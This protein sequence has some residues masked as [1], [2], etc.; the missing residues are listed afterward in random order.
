[1]ESDFDRQK[2]PVSGQFPPLDVNALHSLRCI[3]TSEEIRRTVFS[4][5]KFKA[6]G[7]DGL[8][9][10]FFYT[11]WETIGNSAC[12]MV[13][14]IFIS[15][16]KIQ[17]IN[18]TLICLIPKE[19]VHS[20][21][22]KKGEIGLMAIKI[23][24]EKAYGRLNWDFVY[25]TLAYIGFPT[26]AADIIK[27]CISTSSM[28]LLWNGRTTMD[29]NPTRGIRQGDP[30]SPYLFVLCI[31][32]LS[33]LIQTAMGAKAWKPIR[34]KKNGPWLSH[35]FFAD[36]IFLF[37]DASLKQAV[38]VNQVLRVFCDASGQN[39]SQE[40]T[41]VFFSR[42]VIHVRSKEICDKLGYCMTNDLGGL[43]IRNLRVLNKA[44]IMKLGHGILTNRD[45]LWVQVLRSK[46]NMDDILLPSI[47]Q[48]TVASNLWRGVTKYWSKIL[49]RSRIMI[50]EGMKTKFWM[51]K[52]IPQV[53]HLASAASAPIPGK[54]LNHFVVEYVNEGDS[55]DWPSIT[56]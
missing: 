15:P 55:W 35:L 42:N 39:V 47:G 8:Q 45:A 24:L 38:V 27:S 53:D 30:L 28:N 50:G 1:M 25:D 21:K 16:G 44:F 20:M 29:F 23:D 3:P 12:N 49:E 41:R 9:A 14:D 31:E 26:N 48:S 51:D 56:P 37:M 40:K 32:R 17:D 22:R 7:P 13:K 34:L 36:G 33:H 5:G 6:P 52:W 10:I 4:M 18:N 19:I 54:V 46:Y 2:F 43:G 11:Q